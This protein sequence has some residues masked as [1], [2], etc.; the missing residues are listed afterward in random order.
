MN[1]LLPGLLQKGSIQTTAERYKEHIDEVAGIPTSAIRNM[2]N[3]IQMQFSDISKKVHF[4]FVN[5]EPYSYEKI[6]ELDKDW[7]EGTI[8][9]NCTGNDSLFWGKLYNLQFRAIHDYIHCLHRLNFNYYDEV[10]AYQAQVNFGLTE[11]GKH[12]PFLD[13]ELHNKILRSEIVY[14]AAVS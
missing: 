14:Q 6:E 5:N 11:Y 13:W 4:Q 8:K 3:L 9:V 10:R 1:K 12:I 2:H 7:R